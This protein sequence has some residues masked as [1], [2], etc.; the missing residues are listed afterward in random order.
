VDD[1]NLREIINDLNYALGLVCGMSYVAEG[2]FAD[3]LG[4]V[5]E[6]INDI[7]NRLEGRIDG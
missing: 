6:C 2:G 3:G 1:K 4:G 7:V 5:I